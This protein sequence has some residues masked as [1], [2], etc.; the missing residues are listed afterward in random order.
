MS[1]TPTT[2]LSV[3]FYDREGSSSDS[4]SKVLIEESARVAPRED[5]KYVRIHGSYDSVIAVGGSAALSSTGL[6]RYTQDVLTFSG[7][8]SESLKYPFAERVEIAV[9]GSPVLETS[10]PDHV[11]RFYYDYARGE[12]RATASCYAL[13]RISYYAPYVLFLI[14]FQGSCP[15]LASNDP[16]QD[17]TQGSADDDKEYVGRDPALLMAYRGGLVVASTTL[18][19]PACKGNSTTGDHGA[20]TRLPV[21]RLEVDPKNPPRLLS[22]SSDLELQAG[23]KF[24]VYPYTMVGI[25]N[26]S[27]QVISIDGDTK[28]QV[29]LDSLVFSGSS[30]QQVRYPPASSITVTVVGDFFDIW[31]RSFSPQIALPGS[32]VTVVDWVNQFTY[33]NPRPKKVG[34]DEI[35]V[36]D[37][38]GNVVSGYGVVK[39]EYATTYRE[40]D[41]AFTYAEMTKNFEEAFLFALEGTKVVG[42]LKL[43]PPALKGNK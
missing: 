37:M 33:M 29:V 2:S 36:T 7:S 28:T 17:A 26:T 12:V 35:V 16:P 1:S 27:G 10:D 25:S 6:R 4:S 3:G 22:R 9:I 21:L 14:T 20:G 23:C 31:G 32:N 39:L 18:N 24:R 5:Q 40:Y 34:P 19:A 30:S 42:S 13:L 11:L 8:A 38:F 43:N 15:T 41:F